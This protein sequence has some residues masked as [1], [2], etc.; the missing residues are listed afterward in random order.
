MG[1][2]LHLFKKDD[3]VD[4]SA[5]VASSPGAGDDASLAK[6]RKESSA[7]NAKSLPKPPPKPSSGAATA[8]A[9][10]STASSAATASGTGSTSSAPASDKDVKLKEKLDKEAK[11]SEEMSVTLKNV[12]KQLEVE[13]RR[14]E[15]LNEQ[16]QKTEDI[17][18]RT[19]AALM[20]YEA[21]YGEEVAKYRAQLAELEATKVRLEGELKLRPTREELEA[22][23]NIERTELKN[24][25]QVKQIEATKVHAAHD[26]GKEQVE[27][28]QGDLE[29]R[30][31]ELSTVKAQAAQSDEELVRLRSKLSELLTDKAT[32][33]SVRGELQAM[34][35]ERDKLERD[36]K[37]ADKVK[38]MTAEQ[39]ATTEA[40]LQERI[41]GLQQQLTAAKADTVAAKEH[42]K[43]TLDA[44]K[45]EHAKAVQDWMAEKA[46]LHTQLDQERATVAK[47]QA[48]LHETGVKLDNSKR[49]EA[50]L[51]EKI[52]HL[53]TDKDQKSIKESEALAEAREETRQTMEIL[54]QVRLIPP[55]PIP[56][57]LVSVCLSLIAG[58]VELGACGDAACRAHQGEGLCGQP[59]ERSR[60]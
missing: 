38:A 32:V 7:K 58:P 10:T 2:V 36:A 16:L 50:D 42:G 52:R 13:T 43:H 12:K 28:L 40:Q 20:A 47:L 46:T 37:V 57:V 33:E 25:V 4:E 14:A 18:K 55:P 5:S 30:E 22:V 8:T 27:A 15:E 39:T 56:S 19:G 45:A 17:L 54:K 44:A 3:S 23:W 35:D 11:K 53:L 48:E 21:T 9:S 49:S 31:G 6:D 34:R 26:A 41:E 51:A 59:R 60:A 24:L 1:K 29:R